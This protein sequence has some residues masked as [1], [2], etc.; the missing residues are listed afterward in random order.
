MPVDGC[1]YDDFAALAAAHAEEVDWCR[2]LRRLD[3]G[4]LLIAPHGGRLERGT[5]RI[6]AAI[7]GEDFDL[8]LFL[9]LRPGLQRLLHLP[10]TRFDDPA[11]LELLAGARRVVS[12]HGCGRP[13]AVVHLGG[14][15]EALKSALA[16]AYRAVGLKTVESGHPWPGKRRS[17]ICNRGPS[18]RGVQLELGWELRQGDGAD[19]LIEATRRVLFEQDA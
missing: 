11:C 2:R 8:Y 1:P 17:N 6:A 5:E 9:V 10:S 16:A 12:V 13:G 3:S 14:R 19:P 7:A 18:G 4:T 15:D